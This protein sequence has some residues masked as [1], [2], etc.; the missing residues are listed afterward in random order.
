MNTWAIDTIKYVN[1][2]IKYILTMIDL[3]TRIDYTVALS[4]KKTRYTS[5][6]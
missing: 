3:V 5:I 4:P 2:K 1:N 6:S